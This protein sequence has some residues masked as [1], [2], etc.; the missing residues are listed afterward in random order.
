M[1]Y[2]RFYSKLIGL[3][4]NVFEMKTPLFHK[5]V[6]HSKIPNV[7]SVG[8]FKELTFQTKMFRRIFV[9]YHLILRDYIFFSVS[10]FLTIFDTFVLLCAQMELC[11]CLYMLSNPQ[12]F[13]QSTKGKISWDFGQFVS[14]KAFELHN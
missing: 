2:R 6:F 12:L 3:I 14:V 1:K 11:I 5:N 8:G 10:I 4:P 13:N 7:P 9:K